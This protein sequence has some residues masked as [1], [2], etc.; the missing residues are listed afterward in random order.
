[1]PYYASGSHGRGKIIPQINPK[2]KGNDI[3]AIVKEGETYIPR[4]TFEY[5]YRKDVTLF[6]GSVCPAVKVAPVTIPRNNL[7]AELAQRL[8]FVMQLEEYEKDGKLY[9]LFLDVSPASAEPIAKAVME[10]RAGNNVD[11]ERILI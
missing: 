4:G 3:V 11:L 8:N 2:Y 7:G 5:A 9:V 1:M 10:L 6:S